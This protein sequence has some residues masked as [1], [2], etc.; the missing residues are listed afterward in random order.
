MT[1]LRPRV[2]AIALCLSLS[3]GF[4]AA[5][6]AAQSAPI[7]N[8]E[9][10]ITERARQLFQAGVDFMQDPDGA[11]YAEAY[12]SFK[13]AYAESPSWKILGNLGISAMKVER[14]GEA[15]E[16][17]ETYLREGRDNLDQEE[18]EQVERDLRTLRTAVTYVTLSINEPGAVVEDVRTPLSGQPVNNRYGGDETELRIGVHN[19]R[20]RILVHKEGFETATWSFEASGQDLNHRIDL[21]AIQKAEPK[22]EVVAPIQPQAEP[23]RKIPIATW[24]TLGATAALGVGATATGILALNTHGQ[25]EEEL[26]RSDTDESRA[27]DLRTKGNALNITTDVLLGAAVISATIATVTFLTRPKVAQHR[28][29]AFRLAPAP[30]RRGGGVFLHGRF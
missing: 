21:V 9:V 14:D 30:L 29:S 13:A 20:H 6:S 12:R 27:K 4:V 1:R 19:G 26:N 2:L 23:R 24:I 17:M 8:D 11:R 15:I 28:D 7:A 10:E 3:T 16:A 25:F 22:D 5:P 18:I